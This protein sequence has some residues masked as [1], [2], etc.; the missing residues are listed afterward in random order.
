M[1]TAEQ[2][3]AEAIASGY[4]GEPTPEVLRQFGWEPQDPLMGVE[5]GAPARTAEQMRDDFALLAEE[6]K[7]NNVPAMIFDKIKAL[8]GVALK[9]AKL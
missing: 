7:A 5:I 8:A 2:A 6:A 4:Q 1:K 9:F 3:R